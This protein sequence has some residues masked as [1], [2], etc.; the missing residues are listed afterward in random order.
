[1]SP[2][3]RRFVLIALA[4][5]IAVCG[6]LVMNRLARPRAAIPASFPDDPLLAGEFAELAKRAEQGGARDWLFLGESLLG[7]G[8]YGHAER[9]LERALQLDPG[10]AD[11]A[12]ALGF[13]VDRTGRVAEGNAHY[14]RCLDI[15]ADV[16][17]PGSKKPLALY[18]IGRN[19]LRLGDVAAAEAAFRRNEGFVPALYQ[20]ARILHHSD[21]PQEA[22]ELIGRL[23]GM[24]PL[25]LELH[26]LGAR[27]MER[28]GEPAG[29]FAAAAMEERSAHL[30][31]TSF[32]HAYVRPFAHR[33]G[34]KRL[35]DEYA[36]GEASADPAR[37][38]WELDTLA[39]VV[40]D[41]RL[42]QRMMLLFL[43]GQRALVDGKPGLVPEIVRQIAAGGDASSDRLLLEAGCLEQQGDADGARAL[44]ERALLMSPKAVI[45]R[46]LAADCDRRGDAAGRD[47]HLAGEQ[48]LAAMAAYRRNRPDA[49][50]ELL[51]KSADLVPDDATTWFH[52]G[53]MEYHLGRRD[54]AAEA[55]RTA[56]DL[57]PGYGRA[58]DYLA[59]CAGHAGQSSDAPPTE[60]VPAAAPR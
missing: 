58:R 59:A 13:A 26:Q 25:S 23:L 44:R 49:A 54:A 46:L 27:V 15:S 12:F 40:G 31:E 5:E 20:L 42:P 43:R 28:L 21:R 19:Q 10:D 18:A 50:L 11:A 35:L 9:A 32:A 37:L 24:L 29:R 48:F 14:E 45:E 56:V 47:R 16:P 52:I 3:I 7:Q 2:A 53:E 6:W 55:L 41:R 33:H 38:A 36:A 39:A 22:A 34:L 60:E 1:M 51:R 8:C 30:I 17:T 4:G 57:R